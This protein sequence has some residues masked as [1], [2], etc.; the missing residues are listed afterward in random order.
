MA[1]LNERSQEAELAGRAAPA[2]EFLAL[3]EPLKVRIERYALRSA[4]NREQGQDIVQ[5]AVMT[6]WREFHRFEKGSNFQAWVFRILINTLYSFNKKTNRDQKHGSAVPIESL[7]GVLQRESAWASVLEDPA[8]ILESLDDRLAG[9]I[10]ELRHDERQCLPLRRVEGFTYKAIPSL[11]SMPWGTV[12][13]H[14]CRAVLNPPEPLADLAV[15]QRL[16]KETS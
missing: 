12:M 9:A 6:A 7:D 16:V 10:G 8:R 3:L 11:F 2:Q 14:V 1:V 15:E 5:E 13:S 4:W